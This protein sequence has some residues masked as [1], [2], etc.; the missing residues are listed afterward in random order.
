MIINNTNA[1]T[2]T[3]DENFMKLWKQVHG[4]VTNCLKVKIPVKWAH[5]QGS[6]DAGSSGHTTSSH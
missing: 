1:G 2:V 5:L 3:E 4:F 6:T